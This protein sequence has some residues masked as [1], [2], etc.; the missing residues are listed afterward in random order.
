MPYDNLKD[1]ELN[2]DDNTIN[3]NMGAK[4]GLK[5]LLY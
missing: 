3:I 1:D 4:F 2:N 5:Q